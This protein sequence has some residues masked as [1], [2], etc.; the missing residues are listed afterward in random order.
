MS[1]AR[2]RV[3]WCAGAGGQ[4]D[5]RSTA[6]GRLLAAARR[7]GATRSGPQNPVLTRCARSARRPATRGRALV[8]ASRHCR[9]TVAASHIITPCAQPPLC[10]PG[11]V[12]GQC[13]TL[14]TWHK[15]RAF[16]PEGTNKNIPFYE[17]KR[18][19]CTIPHSLRHT[20]TRHARRDTAGAAS[21]RGPTRPYC[22]SGPG[23]LAFGVAAALPVPRPVERSPT[24]GP[25]ASPSRG[26]G[27]SRAAFMHAR[28]RQ[29]APQAP[30]LW[31]GGCVTSRREAAALLEG[32][33]PPAPGRWLSRRARDLPPLRAAPPRGCWPPRP[34]T[35]SRRPNRGREPSA[36]LVPWFGHLPVYTGGAPPRIFF[37]RNSRKA[38][39]SR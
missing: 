14:A 29:R 25:V 30:A 33:R 15:A 37:W 17:G 24:P 11:A 2:Q 34:E 6:R 39:K 28:F 22:G 35:R 38:L 10:D 3:L 18:P 8:P 20:P 26:M 19:R 7:V 9:G 13:L 16:A 27:A 36:S 32:A 23:L 5:G 31:P 4:N 21:T 1:A 12:P